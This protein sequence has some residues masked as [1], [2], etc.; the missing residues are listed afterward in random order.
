MVIFSVIWSVRHPKNY[1]E[2]LWPKPPRNSRNG[3]GVFGLKIS[4]VNNELT[5]RNL[6][7]GQT[8]LRKKL[9]KYYHI[10][11]HNNNMCIL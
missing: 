10:D 7:D 3:E 2:K 1:G 4:S 11:I 8:K 5:I 6:L 9:R